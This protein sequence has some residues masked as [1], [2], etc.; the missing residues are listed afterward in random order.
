MKHNNPPL[1][2]FSPM[3]ECGGKFKMI[4]RCLSLAFLIHF[5]YLKN[6]SFLSHVGG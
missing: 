5:V 1:L 6:Q 3:L 4:P 2:L